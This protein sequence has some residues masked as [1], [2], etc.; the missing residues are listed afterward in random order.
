MACTSW[1][2][3][4]NENEVESVERASVNVAQVAANRSRRVPGLVIV[5]RR[6]VLVG[7]RDERE[8][9]GLL[10]PIAAFLLGLIQR[11]IRS[12]DQI[13]GGSVPAGN[14]TGKAHADG[15]A[16]TVGMCDA[17]GLNS[18]P[19]CFGHLC[20][21]IC[22]GTGKN[23]H[24]FVAAIPGDEISWSVDGS[25]D[26]SG[27]LTEAFVARRMPESI[28]V[29]F[30]SVDVEHDQRERR[31]FADSTAPFLVQEVVKLPSVGNSRE[32]VKTGQ[33][34]QHLIR[35]LELTHHLKK[36]LLPGPPPVDFMDQPQ[37]RPDASQEL[38]LVDGFPNVVEC[39]CGKGE[40]EIYGI[41]LRG[42]HHDG[43]VTESFDRLDLA[44]SFDAAHFR[45]GNVHEDQVDS[46]GC[47]V[48]SVIE[49]Q[50]AEC[51][52]GRAGDKDLVVAGSR[53]DRLK[54]EA[55]IRRIVNDQDTHTSLIQ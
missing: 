18:L 2:E 33:A 51:G 34:Q 45:H 13:D 7:A 26:S 40:L 4:G 52:G 8:C 27:N 1:E 48:L 10:S 17:E 28:V 24:E 47:A 22:T 9:A 43:R 23:D 53:K 54:Q 46:G 31:Q 38:D 42:D 55:V 21:A 5:R 41:G 32:A 35:F 37:D 50:Q 12:L 29:G 14:R 19:K 25:R 3:P 15:G 39:A 11:L 44:A 49:P 16:A 6:L 20:H 30:E 36:F